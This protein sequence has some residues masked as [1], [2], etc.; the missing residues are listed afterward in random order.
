MASAHAFG[1]LRTKSLA[2]GRRVT[3]DLGIRAREAM[4][5]VGVDPYKEWEEGHELRFH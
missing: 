5:R 4:V 2:A 3:G 1:H